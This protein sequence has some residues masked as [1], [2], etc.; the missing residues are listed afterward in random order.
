MAVFDGRE[1]VQVCPR[2]LRSSK[3]ILL[4]GNAGGGGKTYRGGNQIKSFTNADHF[5]HWSGNFILEGYDI[6]PRQ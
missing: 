4:H 1:F 3:R 2:P 5:T 6:T